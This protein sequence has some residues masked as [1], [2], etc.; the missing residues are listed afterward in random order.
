MTGGNVGCWNVGGRG[1]WKGGCGGVSW[2]GDNGGWKGGDG[3]GGGGRLLLLLFELKNVGLSFSVP[4]LLFIS[5]ST[6][7]GGSLAQCSF[8]FFR[9]RALL[10]TTL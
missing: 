4:N 7:L 5:L 1:G 10:T 8:L 3:G 2:K 6:V 9:N